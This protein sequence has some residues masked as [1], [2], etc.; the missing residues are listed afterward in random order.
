[1]QPT[2]SLTLRGVRVHNLKNINVDIPLHRLTVVTGV[3]GSGKT[4]LVFDALY[5]EAQRRYLQSFSVYTRQFLER[6][7]KPDADT[8]SDL[9]PAIAIRGVPIS[10]SPRVS[11]GSLTEID[12]LLRSWFARA[13]AM[14]CP[15][16]AQPV[17]AQRTADVLAVLQAMPAG[18]RCAIAFL[19]SPGDA[20]DRDAWRAGLQ[21]EGYIRI[22]IGGAV[23]RLDEPTLPAFA[24][25]D[26]IWVQLDRIEI[27]KTAPERVTESLDAGFRRGA[28]RIGILTDTTELVF[29]QQPYCSRCDRTFPTLEP[30][31]FD[32]NDPGGACPTCNGLGVQGKSA[33]VCP[34]CAGRRHHADS[35]AVRLHDRNIADWR[36][37]PLHE[38]LTLVDSV[39]PNEAIRARLQALVGMDL[40]YLT[41][42]QSATTLDDGATRRV[43]LAAALT[44]D[45]VNVL[46]LIDEPTVGLHPRDTLKVR[47]ALLRLRERG[48]TVG[49]IEN[50]RSILA[51]ADHVIDLGPGAGEEGG[52][53]TY[54]GP[55]AG[56]DIAD[57]H[58]TSDFWTCRS[59]VEVPEK[60]RTPTGWLKLNGAQ[61]FAAPL[62]V[63]CAVTGVSG[64]G[65]RS[66]VEHSLY[67]ALCVV[68]GKKPPAGPHPRPLSQGERG[69]SIIGADQISDVILLDQAPLARSGRS[70]PAT[71]LKI[72]DEIRDLFADTVDAKIRNYG[73]GHFSF[74]QPG[75]RCE[76][77][78]G[79]GSLTIDMQFLADVCAIC[80]ECQGQRYRK[81]I[82]AIKVRS[83]S[84]AEV[85]DLTV[86]EA[87]RFFRAQPSIEKKLKVLLDVNLEHL[88]L[89]QALDTLSGSECQR[90]KLAAHLASS[91]KTRVLFL[92]IEPTAGLHPADV[93]DL[94]DCFERLLVAGHSLV[95]I[96][97]DLNVVKCADW[98]IDLDGGRIVVEGTPDIVAQVPESPIGRYLV[99]ELA[100]REA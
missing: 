98:V 46:Y 55:P 10:T 18:S 4:S 63:L 73:P 93:V 89:G 5:A 67:S 27:G 16:C 22:Q 42:A 76:T 72:L 37:L 62:G 52:N 23:Y 2:N 13:G 82:L 59:F 66:L 68:K 64:A 7:D 74:N 34:T 35:L 41:L 54:Q 11:V 77:C 96:E 8:I 45:L 61:T 85:L 31:L 28:G 33:E 40:G 36:A 44:S 25:T 80:N 56:L 50:E 26:R 17:K 71:Q 48:N 58:P 99:A 79:Q 69:A 65:K 100:P 92:L 43:A 87:F 3:S 70:N 91:R 47:D 29:D 38:M 12:A 53:I 84:I 60:R 90:L 32:A 97:N 78:E 83:L 1:M 9:P 51:A 6:F 81:E 24:P 21:E 14:I 39:A 86:R 75:G 20:K 95:V 94:L 57:E 15:G 88:R 49:V 19:T 30:R